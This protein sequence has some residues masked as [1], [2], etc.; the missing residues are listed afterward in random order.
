MNT[1]I[2]TGFVYHPDYLKHHAGM[3][4]PESP[5]RLTAIVNGVRDSGLWEEVVHLT[6]SPATIE[7][8]E[9]IHTE[10]YVKFLQEFC[11][12]GGGS[13]ELDTS[14]SRDS[15]DVALL[16]VGGVIKAIDVVMNGEVSNAFAVVRPPGHHALPDM[17]KGFCLFNNVAIGT[18]YLQK[19]YNLE[20]ILIVDWDVHHGDGTHYTFYDD[21]SVFYFSIHQFPF[22][23]GT[24]RVYETGRGAGAGYT[25]NVP[26]P[27]GTGVKEYVDA[28]RNKLIPM[29]LKYKPDFILIS[30][31][32]DGHEDDPI[33]GIDLT[34][35]SYGQLTDIVCEIADQICDGRIVSSLEGGYN[36]HALSESVVEHLKHL[37]SPNAG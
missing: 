24:G 20:R 26:V 29:A 28:F 3:F 18:R 13:L 37:M 33:S 21:P 35:I 32:F 36:L 25:L 2:Y 11:A 5:Q 23:P 12:R 16:A 8:V 10:S 1:K 19:D 17:G 6:P 30:A 34:S 9:Y 14:V 27:F 4:H 15:F 22:Y 7:Q 31:G